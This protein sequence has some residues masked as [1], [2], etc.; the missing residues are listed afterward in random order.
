M[1]K[2]LIVTLTLIVLLGF[3][4]DSQTTITLQPGA[5]D[6]ED[7]LVHSLQVMA[8]SN[9]GYSPQFPGNAATHN[10]DPFINRALV[11]F[12]LSSIPAGAIINSAYLS[13]YA[14]GVNTGLGWH[15]TLS[16]SN[17]CLLQRITSFWEEHKVTWN[18]QPT[19]TTVNQVDI[20]ESTNPTQDYLNIDVTALVQDMIA[21]PATSFGF[22]LKLK[23]ESYY[24][25]LNFCSSDHADST[26]HPK[27]VIT[28]TNT[29]APDT[30]ITLQPDAES[31]KDALVHS[32]SWLADSNLGS[33]P[34]F[35]G[36]AATWGGMPFINRSFL[37]FNMAWIPKGAVI[38]S[39][40]LSLYAWGSNS[41][42]G[43]HITL[44]GTNICWL[45]RVV[46]P[47]DEDTVTW[48]NQPTSTTVNRV[49]LPESTSPNQDYLNI[50][51]TALVQDMIDNPT[52][53]FGFMLKL[54]N[55]S[56]WR[57]LNF[58]TSDHQDP[59]KFPKIEICYAIPTSVQEAITDEEKFNVYPN[60]AKDV[61]SVELD[62][63][64]GE[65]YSIELINMQGKVMKRV[66]TTKAMES[67]D[68]TN[69]SQGLL[70]I[71]VSG[72]NRSW[73][74]KLIIN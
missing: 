63:I 21:N 35:P 36:N 22:L 4:V 29:L 23:N 37:K 2:N 44:S 12:D 33:N 5:A 19:S 55:E 68:V 1:K 42:L 13:L 18:K 26:K 74:K 69:C 45:E 9:F 25:R 16:G 43:P 61:I 40:L 32:L 57:R 30:C 53:S 7:A 58:C 17:E 65:K 15:I 60:P 39:A 52:T 11:D 6:G 59:T 34:Q 71:K 27:I 62:N 31:G 47:W 10:L 51:V 70:F 14:W 67:I 46:S 28:Y 41:G 64:M 50:N 72:K 8:D 20:P 48:N 56:H 73:S 49:Q 24:R 38:T 66:I 3:N 54:D